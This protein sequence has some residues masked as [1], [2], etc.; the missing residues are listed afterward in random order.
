MGELKKLKKRAKE[1]REAIAKAKKAEE[2]RKKKNMGG[3][4]GGFPGGFPGGMP[5]GLPGA[6]AGA[7]A[8]GM[9]PGMS[10]EFMQ[11][12]MSD[13]ELLAAIQEPGVMEKLLAFRK[14]PSKIAS[15]KDPKLKSLVTKLQKLFGDKGPGAGP[16]ARARGGCSSS[17]CGD[18]SCGSKSKKA[19]GTAKSSG[20]DWSE[21]DFFFFNCVQRQTR[22]VQ[23]R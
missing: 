5:G 22:Y 19:G 13:P 1:R 23:S 14:D 4:P 21:V 10:P 6:G 11:K 8:G 9:P 17:K 20:Q 15:I 18:S 3:M 2:Q 12:I 7:G 16:G